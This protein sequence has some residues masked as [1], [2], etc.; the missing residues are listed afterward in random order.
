[1]IHEFSCFHRNCWILTPSGNSCSERGKK[2]LALSKK[3]EWQPKP[4]A[5]CRI[6]I[7]MTFG[8]Y[9]FYTTQKQETLVKRTK[10]PID[11]QSPHSHF[12]PSMSL[13]QLET[14]VRSINCS[15]LIPVSPLLFCGNYSKWIQS[16]AI[17]LCS[18]SALTGSIGHGGSMEEL[19]FR[20]VILLLA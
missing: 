12:C 18:S 16:N 6:L 14:P 9:A 7:P 8:Y 15:H 11:K 1:M 10:E 19:F 4:A 17:L 20:C 3:R 2:I 5:E 13:Q